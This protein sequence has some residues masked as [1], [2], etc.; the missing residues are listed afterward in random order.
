MPI[1]VTCPN[2]PTKLSAPDS[3]AGKQV[4][5]PKCG[6]AAPV[7]ALIPAE[8]VPV[9]DATPLPP[10]PRPKPVLAEAADDERLRKKPRDDEDADEVPR[11]KARHDE[12]EEEEERPRKK[13]RYADDDDDY[14]FDHP[15]RKPRPNRG[16]GGAML[17][18]IIVGGLALLIGLGV[19]IY[20]LAGKGSAFAKKAP[21]PKGWEA[22]SN[23][24]AGVKMCVPKKPS[25]A[26]TPV[27]GIGL[28][29]GGRFGGPNL[30]DAEML[31]I[32][33][34]GVTGDPVHVEVFVIRFRNSV[35]ASVRDKIFN[36]PDTPAGSENR[37]VRWLGR[38]AMEQTRKEGVARAACFDKVVVV[39][40]VSGRNG[41]ATKA[42][43]DGFFDNFELTK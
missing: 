13:K 3:A 28:G 15:R 1:V 40:A 30:S 24:D 19:G 31:S 12:D 23:A 11:Q 29:G 43:E 36:N 9:V 18:V 10:K 21:T 32:I 8:E 7:P 2:C 26:T 33:R 37:T 42:E 39:A 4:R 22:Y 25:E 16:A 38:D 35:P 14:D 34:S 27:N 17:A 6:A 5:C 41:R 20:F